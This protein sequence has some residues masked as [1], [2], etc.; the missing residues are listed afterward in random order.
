MRV[1]A[2]TDGRWCGSG[3]SE[4]ERQAGAAAV[5]LLAS[6]IWGASLDAAAPVGAAQAAPFH[7]HH[8]LPDAPLGNAAIQTRTALGAHASLDPM[9][10]LR[11]LLH[12][13]NL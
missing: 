12:G 7:D 2:G 11:V 4:V 5:S 10:K 1:R 9:T 6:R 13:N 8:H 3:W